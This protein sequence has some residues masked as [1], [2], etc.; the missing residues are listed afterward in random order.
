[1]QST[2][3]NHPV[4]IL[5]VDD[6]EDMRSLLKDLL[7][8]DGFETECASN[9]FDALQEVAGRNF[10]L[11]ITDIGMPGLTGLDI[12]PGIRRL[13]PGAPVIVM[14]SFASRHVHRRSLERGATG[15]L[16]KPIR[17]ENLRSLIYRHIKPR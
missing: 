2:K 3:D 13:R 12:L 17:I 16:E 6:D 11:I 8:E 10:D 4:R 7:E 14:S 1:M 5:I 9:G 15:Y